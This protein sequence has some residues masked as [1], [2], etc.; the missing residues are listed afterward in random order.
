[1]GVQRRDSAG[2]RQVGPSWESLIER[3]IREAVE[4][5]AF[6]ELPHQGEPLP[7]EDDAPAGEWAVAHRILR[8]AGMAP[9]WIEADKAVRALLDE[10]ERLVARA[11][12]A[13]LIA[14]PRARAE[15]TRIVTD[16]NRAILRLNSE[17]PT[18]RQHRIPLDRDAEMARLEAAFPE[19]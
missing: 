16:A 13:S 19:R 8:N 2:N 4:R 5:G 12:R 6:D 14:Q 9:G 11:P 15:L 17:A 18:P 10:L 7:L 3:Q 1:M